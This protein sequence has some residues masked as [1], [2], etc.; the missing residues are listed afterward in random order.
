PASRRVP[1]VPPS[2]EAGVEAFGGSVASRVGSSRT[3]TPPRRGE[4]TMSF[5]RCR[6]F[7]VRL[8]RHGLNMRKH[9]LPCGRLLRLSLC[10]IISGATSGAGG[11]ELAER[12]LIAMGTVLNLRVSGQ[13]RAAALDA[14][15][16]AAREVA[17]I[18][19][20]LSTWKTGGPLDRLNHSR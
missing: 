4:L 19:E 3:R 12:R 11:S 7:P 13:D 1:P 8:L 20:L 10:L 14:S 6:P 16:A 5:A 15:E 2:R 9:R 17:R 18:E